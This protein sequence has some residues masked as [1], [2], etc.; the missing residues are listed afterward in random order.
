VSFLSHAF[1]SR[2]FLSY[3]LTG[4]YK[5]RLE[6]R[7]APLIVRPSKLYEVQNPRRSG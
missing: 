3:E 5:P 1:L 4:V 2:D 6:V 7:D